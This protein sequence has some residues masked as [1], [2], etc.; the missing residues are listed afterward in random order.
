[1]FQALVAFCSILPLSC[2]MR[3]LVA[4][5]II[6]VFF[7]AVT[8]CV[9]NG[10]AGRLELGSNKGQIVPAGLPCTGYYQGKNNHSAGFCQGTGY[11][12]RG[13]CGV[14]A[15]PGETG[16]Y[17]SKDGA[18]AGCSL[19][20]HPGGRLLC[21]CEHGV[22]SEGEQCVKP[23]TPRCQSCHHG[24]TLNEKKTACEIGGPRCFEL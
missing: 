24:Y 12:G 8:K 19:A 10:K 5:Y 11:G 18:W 2:F 23:D 7:L 4:T 20:C 22:P 16:K 14:E 17:T 1:M 15:P 13:W 6:S 21:K 3:I 9:S